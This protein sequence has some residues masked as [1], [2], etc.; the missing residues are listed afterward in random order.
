MKNID[1]K[2]IFAKELEMSI[3]N[4]RYK[5]RAECQIDILLFQQHVHDYITSLNENGQKA[6]DG[7]HH[8]IQIFEMTPHTRADGRALP[9]TSVVFECTL[10]LNNLKLRALQL[11]D[12]H[13]IGESLKL[14]SEYDGERVFQTQLNVQ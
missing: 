5:Y 7:G 12:C 14:E 13:V 4:Q 11:V 10:S 1:Q 3:P 9:D 2:A 8:Y 6:A